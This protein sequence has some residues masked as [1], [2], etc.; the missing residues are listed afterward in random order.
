LLYKLRK[1]GLHGS[2]LEWFKDYLRKRSQKVTIR[3][4]SSESG[5]IKGGVPQGSVLG[6]LLFLI[7]INDITEGIQSKIK[8]FAD[9]TSLYIDFK[10][11]ELA[12]EKLNGDLTKIGNWAKQWLVNFSPAKTKSIMCSNKKTTTPPI[13]FNNTE[14]QDTGNHKHLGLTLS[15]D[16]SWSAHIR[17][18]L[19][20]VSA[21][22]SVLKRLKYDVDRKSLEKIYFSFIRPK[23]EYASHVWAN[24]YDRDSESL[25]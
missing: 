14:L 15:D 21:M 17:D 20:K 19:D 9:D 22:S 8:L 5:I 4:Q 2:L 10:D 7:Y 1:I 18:I 11:P 24:C 25:E 13:Y 23:L 6:P 16:L 3:G 12:A